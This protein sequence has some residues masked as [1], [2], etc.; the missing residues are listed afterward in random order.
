LL[1]DDF[2]TPRGASLHALHL[3][4][5]KIAQHGTGGFITAVAGDKK[6]LPKLGVTGKGGMM[7]HA[8]SLPR[9]G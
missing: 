7:G 5:H 2:V 1:V 6:A 3:Q 4:P 8:L 9:Q